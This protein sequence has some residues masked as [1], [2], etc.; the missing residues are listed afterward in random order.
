MSAMTMKKMTPMT[1]MVMNDDN[2]NE[3]DGFTIPTGPSNTR[4]IKEDTQQQEEALLQNETTTTPSYMTPRRNET[5]TTTTSIIL[6]TV[7]GVCRGC[8]LYDLEDTL[9]DDISDTTLLLP[10]QVRKTT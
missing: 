10:K 8:E 1:T 6:F 2:D 5:V 4:S 3:V 7:S 9:F